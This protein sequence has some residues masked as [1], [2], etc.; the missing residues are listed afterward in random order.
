MKKQVKALS[1]FSGGLDSAL[2]VK[3]LEDQNIKVDAICFCSNFFG[4]EKAKEMAEQIGIN[5]RVVDFRDEYLELVKNPPSGYGKNLNPCIDCHA[6]MIKKAGEIAKKE[7]Y[8]IVATGEVYGQRPFSQ[9]KEALKRVKKISGVDVLRPLSAKLIEETEAERAGLVNR[10]RLLRINGR[11]RE[12]QFELTKK[13]GIKKFPSP[14]GGCILTDPEF[15]D[16]L[17]KMLENYPNCKS[18]DVELLKHGRVFWFR[19]K[20]DQKALLV[21]GRHKEDNERLEK[22]AQSDDF[23]LELKEING[24]ISILR[25]WDEKEKSRTTK[26]IISVHSPQKLMMAE[27][28][29]LEAKTVDEIL[30]L[31]AILTSHYATK[32]RGKE[33]EV[34]IINRLVA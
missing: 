21:I 19:T 29:I 22:L 18:G 14:A 5:L 16:R 30:K 3:I 1:L 9:N 11:Q 32:T 2:A 12:D 10:G 7:G 8:D 34:K 6:M 15:S 33:V 24:P 27:L 28:R 26:N 31:S 20:N 23:M 13:Y 4:C 17:L 25:F